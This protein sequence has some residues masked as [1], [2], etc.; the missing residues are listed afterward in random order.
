MFGAVQAWAKL[1]FTLKSI[2]KNNTESGGGCRLSTEGGGVFTPKGGKQISLSLP[3]EA[4]HCVL[5]WDVQSY[6]LLSA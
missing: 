5:Q 1:K 4:R 2:R 3:P 6:Q